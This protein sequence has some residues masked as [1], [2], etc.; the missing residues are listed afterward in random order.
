MT[1]FHEITKPSK[2]YNNFT[3]QIDLTQAAS[4]FHVVVQ[5]QMVQQEEQ[6]EH[7]KT[8]VEQQVGSQIVIG[9]S[10]CRRPRSNSL[11]KYRAAIV[12]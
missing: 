4:A 7:S 12:G 9:G 11:I 3:F 2:Y 8:Q 5:I 6:P 10:S 1:I